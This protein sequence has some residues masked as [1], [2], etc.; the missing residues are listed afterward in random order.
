MYTV[1]ELIVDAQKHSGEF[2]IS[3]VN[4]RLDDIGRA[5]E[6]RVEIT[7]DGVTSTVCD[8]SWSDTDATV[9]CKMLGFEYEMV[10]KLNYEN[11]N[12][13]CI[14]LSNRFYYKSSDW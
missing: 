9:V 4:G 14:K 3:L 1:Y 13:Q 6:G 12:W 11:V 2:N 8:D 10:L 5:F 7:E